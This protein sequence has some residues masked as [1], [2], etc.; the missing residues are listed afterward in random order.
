MGKVLSEFRP[1]LSST[2]RL[3]ARGVNKKLPRV[4]TR[5]PSCHKHHPSDSGLTTHISD[6]TLTIETPIY[7]YRFKHGR[8][9]PRT[10]FGLSQLCDIM[11]TSNQND[12]LWCWQLGV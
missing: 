3:G 12:Y 6:I 9:D 11:K 1:G 8:R 7:N 2:A 4:I 5:K 10:V